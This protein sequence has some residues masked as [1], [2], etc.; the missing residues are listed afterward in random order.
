MKTPKIK[1]RVIIKSIGITGTVVGSVL[2]DHN[3]GK[4]GD[5]I[6]IYN[7]IIGQNEVPCH[8]TFSPD[9]LER[10]LDN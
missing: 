9:N 7:R 8:G 6:V 5:L 3:K 1:D 10:V 2:A 4:K